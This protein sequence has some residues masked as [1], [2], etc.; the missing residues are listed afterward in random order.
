ML[1]NADTTHPPSLEKAER[2]GAVARGACD[3]SCARE[4]L[5]IPAR[6]CWESFLPLTE[7]III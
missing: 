1:R 4:Q 2:E 3:T 6:G 5:K 7:Q